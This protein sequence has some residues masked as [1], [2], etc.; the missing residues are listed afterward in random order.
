MFSKAEVRQ[1]L[2]SLAFSA[3][4]LTLLYLSLGPR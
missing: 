1:L 2:S 3:L 4:G